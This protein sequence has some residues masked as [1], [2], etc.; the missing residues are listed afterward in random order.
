MLI[1]MGIINCITVE[2][3]KLIIGDDDWNLGMMLDDVANYHPNV[4]N[5]HPNFLF[6]DST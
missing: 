3:S 5:Y 2:Y 4:G 6:G 1:T